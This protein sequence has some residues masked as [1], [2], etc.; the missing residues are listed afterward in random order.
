V[1]YA[2]IG[3][4][5]THSIGR[6]LIALNFAQRRYEADFRFNLVR[7]RENA[8]GVALYQ[9]HV[10]CECHLYFEMTTR[11]GVHARYSE[12][13]QL[14]RSTSQSRLFLEGRRDAQ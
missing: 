5:L 3:S 4:W 6:P 13:F 10:V 7:F 11:Q 12:S 2:A 1:G 8:E 14:Q 9:E